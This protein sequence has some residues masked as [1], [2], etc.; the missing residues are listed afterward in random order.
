MACGFAATGLPPPILFQ[1]MRIQNPWRVLRAERLSPPA[2]CVTLS[3]MGAGARHL[4]ELFRQRENPAGSGGRQLALDRRN[5]WLPPTGTALPT[6]VCSGPLRNRGND[7]PN[8]HASPR[9]L[10][11]YPQASGASGGRFESGPAPGSNPFSMVKHQLTQ[12]LRLDA[13]GAV[14]GPSAV[15]PLAERRH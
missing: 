7:R 4:R 14:P 8:A 6:T 5:R 12:R 1:M 2:N 11:P 13:A 15:A 10:V 9:R 3:A